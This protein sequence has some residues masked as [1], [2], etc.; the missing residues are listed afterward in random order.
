MPMP[1]PR[2]SST[3]SGQLRPNPYAAGTPQVVADEQQP[4]HRIAGL[5]PETIFRAVFFAAGL[6]FMGLVLWGVLW[7]RSGS[8]T[9]NQSSIAPP[10]TQPGKA[11][12]Q[13]V[14]APVVTATRPSGPTTR[15]ADT[16]ARTVA[17]SWDQ[18]KENVALVVVMAHYEGTAGGRRIIIDVPVASGTAFGVSREGVMLTNRHVV[19]AGRSPDIPP[20]LE[21]VGLPTITRRG[22]ILK[23]CFGPDASQHFDAKA[24][25]TSDH[26]DLAVLKVD[27]TFE[28]PLP[29]SNTP[30]QQGDDVFVCGYPGDVIELLNETAQSHDRRQAFLEK[31]RNTGTFDFLL[32]MFSADSF[33]STLTRGIVS[34]PERNIDGVDYLQTDA[35][36]NQGNSGGPALNER[37]EVVGI[38]TLKVTSSEKYNF[39][40]LLDQLSDELLPYVK[41][42]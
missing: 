7:W 21:S 31:A 15:R 1:P 41:V 27:R 13:P 24:E 16:S 33:N 8:A 19:K 6:L 40:M 11:S 17:A 30:C 4:P 39:A 9:S 22:T 3:P 35:G 29:L 36:V 26:F 20:T 12:I 25:F 32:G 2:M 28:H 10:T 18:L 37:H 5:R 42:K 14:A 23:A 34:A 38:V